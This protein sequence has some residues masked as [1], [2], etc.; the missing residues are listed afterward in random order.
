[1]QLKISIFL[2]LIIYG[3]ISCSGRKEKFFMRY[4]SPSPG[5]L[6][7]TIDKK[8]AEIRQSKN[9]YDSFYIAVELA[10]N[11]TIASRENEAVN[12]LESYI[13]NPPANASN[14]DLVWLYLNFATANQ[15]NRNADM[16]DD[17]FKRALIMAEKYNLD[18]VK[19]YVHHHYGRLLVE[20][21]DYELAKKHF[22][23]ALTIREKLKDKRIAITQ[24]A[25]DSLQVIMNKACR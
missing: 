5:E 25:I 24:K 20:K 10:E 17:Y 12:I 19:H 16:A 9:E 18:S 23:L 6:E 1:M 7:K 2:F 22:N 13:K 8:Y 21:R 15:Y 14:E 3:E 11:L 4:V